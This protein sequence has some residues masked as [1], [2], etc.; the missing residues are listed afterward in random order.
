MLLDGSA[1]MVINLKHLHLEVAL[2]NEEA[3]RMKMSKILEKLYQHARSFQQ[4]PSQSDVIMFPKVSTQKGKDKTF[5]LLQCQFFLTYTRISMGASY[6]LWVGEREEV[7][8][9][10]Y[11]SSKL[12]SSCSVFVKLFFKHS[13]LKP[14]LPSPSHAIYTFWIKPALLHISAFPGLPW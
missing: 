10:N 8:M 12:S 1:Y 3:T 6:S 5:S 9:T 2:T 11:P 13:S 14:C 7:I 4:N